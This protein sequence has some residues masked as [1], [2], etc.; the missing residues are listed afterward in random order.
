MQA[1]KRS[2]GR[3]D[4]EHDRTDRIRAVASCLCR[5][6]A[7]I[8]RHRV[9]ISQGGPSAAPDA[10]NEAEQHTSA[11]DR[12]GYPDQPPIGVLSRAE[13]RF[14]NSVA[15]PG[16]DP[17]NANA[18][19]LIESAIEAAQQSGVL[20]RKRSE[21]RS[22]GVSTSALVSPARFEKSCSRSAM[23]HNMVPS[24]GTCA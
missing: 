9:A 18:L 3:R 11:P 6:I 20:L 13:L 16:H 15:F 1:K 17:E 14:L 8:A 5:T 22:C 7:R 10:N 23:A 4:D 2:S 21:S 19:V 12:G 24:N